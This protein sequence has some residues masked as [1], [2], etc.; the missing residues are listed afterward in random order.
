MGHVPY[1][2]LL[3]AAHFA[4]RAWQ[5]YRNKGRSIGA[6]RRRG[7]GGTTKRYSVQA[8]R[9]ASSGFGLQGG[10][11]LAASRVRWRRRKIPYRKRKQMK[12]SRYR[13]AKFARKVR[14]AL[15]HRLKSSPPKWHIYRSTAVVN[16]GSGGMIANGQHSIDIA[17]GLSSHY[18]GIVAL[19][20]VAKMNVGINGPS[21]TWSPWRPTGTVQIYKSYMVLYMTNNSSTPVYGKMAI[22]RPRKGINAVSLTPGPCASSDIEGP[23]SNVPNEYVGPGILESIGMK[24]RY[25][26]Y[27]GLTDLVQQPQGVTDM[28]FIWQNSPSFKRMYKIKMKNIT[29]APMECK[30]FRFKMK[31]T[32]NVDIATEYTL[33]PDTTGTSPVHFLGSD[34]IYYLDPLDTGNMVMARGRGFFVSFLVHGIPARTVVD[35]VE[36]GVSLTMPKFDIYWLNAY[37]YGWRDPTYREYHVNPNPLEAQQPTMAIPG[38]GTLPGPPQLG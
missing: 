8:R 20:A 32:V 4:H 21:S 13:R 29:W 37:K 6:V 23:G 17:H 11:M 5:A 38:F 22:C 28:G 33:Q 9:S 7:Y 36:T 2:P 30:Q 26:E 14:R 34:P 19:Q 31:K 24:D 1:L 12:M 35:E 3:S 16:P 25:D 15:P 18:D 27:T 10:A